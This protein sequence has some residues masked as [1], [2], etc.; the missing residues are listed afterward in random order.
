MMVRTALFVFATSLSLMF[1]AVCAANVPAQAVPE[2]ATAV[3][4]LCVAGVGAAVAR[5]RRP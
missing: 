5:L 1:P 3:L 2:P 4:M